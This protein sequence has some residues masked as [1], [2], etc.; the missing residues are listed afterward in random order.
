[1]KKKYQILVVPDKFKGSLTSEQVVCSIES[2]IGSV[3]DKLAIKSFALAD[4]GEGS[5]EVVMRAMP[6]HKILT[7]KTVDPLGRDLDCEVLR[8]GETIFIESAKCIGLQLVSPN[9]RN[10]LKE[11]TYGLGVLIKRAME[12]EGI[13][14]IY[15]SIGGSATNDGGTG[16]LSALGF[17]FLDWKKRELYPGNGFGELSEIAEIDLS[18][19]TSL[20][21]I[22]KE[23][24]CISDV[25]N[26]LLGKSGA[27][28]VYGEQK[29]ADKAMQSILEE[30]MKR[31]RDVSVEFLGKDYSDYAGAGAAGGLGYA[32]KAFLKSEMIEG[33]RFFTDLWEIEKEVKEADIVITGEGKLDQQSLKGKLPWGIGNLCKKYNKPLV[34]VC[35]VSTLERREYQDIGISK[36]YTLT[37]IE[38]DI[39]LS[40]KYADKLLTQLS[41]KIGLDLLREEE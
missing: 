25:N 32:F 24:F 9:E 4:G 35:G 38:E 17:R 7:Y 12:E 22:D 31:Y 1:M 41:A 23:I 26:P 18:E 21:R 8:Y 10:P 15:V 14:K 19:P 40:I 5:M 33:W 6:D 16:M 20:H 28:M 29:G 30:I 36:V 37:D 39:T 34:A 27:T 3:S 11:S 13:R 2:G